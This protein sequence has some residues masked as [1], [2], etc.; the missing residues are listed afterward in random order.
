MVSNLATHG[1][2]LSLWRL[3]PTLETG[4]PPENK[5]TLTQKMNPAFFSSP[6]PTTNHV[7]LLFDFSRNQQSFRLMREWLATYSVQMNIEQDRRQ[8]Q[9]YHSPHVSAFEIKLGNHLWVIVECADSDT[10]G[11]DRELDPLFQWY[12][13]RLLVARIVKDFTGKC[14]NHLLF[15]RN[16]MDRRRIHVPLIDLLA[17]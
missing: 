10:P 2:Q 15:V 1:N 13:P 17:F 14:I 5:G 4:V 9:V 6:K 16:C 8:S 7:V 12:A 11:L 3:F